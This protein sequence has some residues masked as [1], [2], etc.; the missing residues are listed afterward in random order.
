MREEIFDVVLQTTGHFRADIDTFQ[1]NRPPHDNFKFSKDFWVGRLPNGIDSKLVLDACDPAGFNHRPV[2]QYG[3]RYAFCN[4]VKPDYDNYYKWDSDLTIGVTLFLSRLYRPTTI[5]NCYSARLYFE[6]DELKTIVAG[7]TQGLGAYAW[8]VAKDNWRNWLSVPEFEQLSRLSTLYQT[9]VPDRVRR[10]RK[11]I[12]NAFHAYYLDQRFA[13]LVTAF[14]SLLKV[15]DYKSTKQFSSRAPRLAEML[16]YELTDIEAE[17]MYKDRS[18]FVHGSEV[19][20]N[21]LSDD[22]IEQYNRFERV[23][24][25]ALLRASTELPFAQLFATPE[26]VEKT[27]GK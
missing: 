21:E 23:I 7:P 1:Q 8:V 4:K 9:S 14:E 25:L 24:R 6:G 20:F 10:A 27:F 18:A 11:H 2:R 17:A 5:S 19:S 12:D 26:S 16:G 13:S 15:S 3:M 22:L